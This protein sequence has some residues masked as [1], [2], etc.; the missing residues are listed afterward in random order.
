MTLQKGGTMHYING[1]W[2][3]GTGD[4]FTS[5]NP[6]TGETIWRGNAADSEQVEAAVAAAHSAFNSWRNTPLE[7]RIAIL[8]ALRDRLEAHKAEL[9]ALISEEVGKAPWDAAG[10]AAATIGKLAACLAAY[11]ERTGEKTSDLNGMQS[12][13]SH[14]PHGVMAVYGPY[15]FPTHIAGG[16]IM[17]A[18]LA[19]NTVVFKPSELTPNT[20]EWYMR[21]LEAAGLPAGVLN[22][23]Q[24]E[25]PTGIALSNANIQGL[26][27]TGSSR[28]GALLHKQFGGRPEVILALE[29]GGNNPLI[30]DAGVKPKAAALET[31][32]SAFTGSGQR[33]TCAR[34]LIIVGDQPDYEAALLELIAHLRI[35][36]PEAQPAPFM[37]PVINNATAELLLDAQKRWIS[38]GAKPLATMRRL[39]DSLPFLSAGL[40]DVSHVDNIED[41]EYFGPLLK[42]YR[43]PTLDD[44]F[45]IANNTRFGLSAAILTPNPAHGERAIQEINAGLININQQTT[46]ASGCNPFGGVGLSGN[47]QPAGYYAADYCAYPV[48]SMQKPTLAVPE[49]L[50]PGLTL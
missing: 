18:L 17:P 2:T 9:A 39:Q 34:R 21:Q 50:P 36:P 10:E 31:V 47:H 16:H 11:T 12:R 29:L 35:G 4:A 48:A 44:A 37:G 22:L 26:L 41:E 43:A 28:T 46:G 20:S 40:V 30:V 5:E 23:V 8:T 15:N 33:C 24:G 25:T 14:R 32:L 13:L 7:E 3:H 42:L 6:S 45:A 49:K 27:F 1:E 38:L 19:G